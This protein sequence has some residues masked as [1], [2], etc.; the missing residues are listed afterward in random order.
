[1]KKVSSYNFDGNYKAR[2]HMAILIARIVMAEVVLAFVGVFLN[3][4]I[5][6]SD[7]SKLDLGTNF[8]VRIIFL[9]LS[10]VVFI[11]L[12]LGWNYK[13]YIVSPHSISS[14]SGIIVRK[15]QSIDIPAVRSVIVNQSFFGRILG[16]GTLSLESPLL[17]EHFLMENL[18]NPFRHATLIEKARLEAIEKMGAENIIISKEPPKTEETA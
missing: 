7:A 3:F 8:Y 15:A 17:E 18:P 11:Y 9:G 2:E 6:A 10:L 1:M 14:N 16:Y 13:Y 4:P 12:L 5:F